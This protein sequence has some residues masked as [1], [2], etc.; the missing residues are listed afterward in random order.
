MAH[1]TKAQ[2]GFDPTVTRAPGQDYMRGGGYDYIVRNKKGEETPYRT[3][4]IIRDFS[5]EALHGRATRIF[6]AKELVNGVPSGDSVVL[7][8][9][10][11]ASSRTREHDTMELIRNVSKKAA[12]RGEL[13]SS[14]LTVVTA[15]DVFVPDDMGV[16]T[17]DTTRAFQLRGADSILK[18]GWVDLEHL[19]VPPV[20]VDEELDPE[21]V[22][23]ASILA[24]LSAIP[25]PK[26]PQITY[27][28][29]VHFRIVYKEVCTPLSDT[30]DMPTVF[31]L[32]GQT[33]TG[34]PPSDLFAF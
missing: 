15:G 11:V 19:E 32:V 29:L 10:W 27:D 20:E 5:V 34:T 24:G 8:D 33:V 4:R 6:E 25:L 3:V 28:D 7:K 22:G 30:T 23:W 1:S 12:Y 21:A 18:A 14:F 9:Q 26:R 16:L 13:R 2:L 17:A 31:K